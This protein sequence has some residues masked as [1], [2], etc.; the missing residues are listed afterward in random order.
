MCL[1]TQ[2]V[3]AVSKAQNKQGILGDHARSLFKLLIAC[4]QIIGISGDWAPI[5]Q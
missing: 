1:Q 5:R 2:F 3:R 4:E